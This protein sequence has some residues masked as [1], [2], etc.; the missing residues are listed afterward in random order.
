MLAE[1]QGL[2]LMNLKTEINKYDNILVNNINSTDLIVNT[3]Y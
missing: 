3:V 2:T 1:T